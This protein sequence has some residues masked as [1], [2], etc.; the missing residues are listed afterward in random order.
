MREKSVQRRSSTAFLASRRWPPP[1]LPS[2]RCRRH[3]KDPWKFSHCSNDIP[4]SSEVAAAADPTGSQKKRELLRMGQQ[5]AGVQDAKI[6]GNV[7]PRVS[8]QLGHA[9]DTLMRRGFNYNFQA[10]ARPSCGGILAQKLWVPA[11]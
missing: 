10:R 7:S 11:Y 3:A 1:R 5:T 6:R 4:K 8:H 2:E 9:K